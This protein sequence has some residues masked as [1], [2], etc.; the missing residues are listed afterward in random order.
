MSSSR[1][2]RLAIVAVAV[3]ALVAGRLFV[4]R[5]T[6]PTRDC[7]PIAAHPEWS[8]ARRWDEALLDAIRRA[9]PNPPVHARNLFHASVA[10][11]DAW[12]TY[13]PKASG[14]L[15]TEKHTAP[16]VAA[17]R[18]EAI[19][20]AAYRVLS[21]RY[22]KAVGGSDSLSEFDDV[23]DSLCYP[24][25]TTTTD[26]DSPAAIGNRI[27]ATVL[28]AAKS[29]GSNEANGYASDYK[30]VNP[31]LVVDK[32]GA[33]P[34]DPN[35]WQP[36]QLEHMISQN[37]IPVTNGVQQ[38]IGPHWGHVTS[39]ALP[40]GGDAGTP[41]DPGPPPQLGG[42]IASDQAY[43]DQAV[44][45]IRDSSLLDPS[46]GTMIDVSPAARG[47]NSLGS[48]DG[49]GRPTNPETGKPYEPERVNQGDFYRVMAEFW[50]DGPKSE[51][52]PGHWNVLANAASDELAPNLRIGGTGPAVDRLQWDVK[53][54]LALNGAV[55]DAA[56][57]AWGLKGRYDSV[58]PITMIRYMGGLGQSSDPKGPSYNR[59]GLPLVPGLIEVVTKESSA[60]RQRHAALARSIGKI[61]IKAWGGI[62]ADPKTQTSGARWML[63]GD[64]VPYQ[65]PTFVTPSFPAFVSGHSTFSRAAA[66]VLTGFTGSE[67]FPG[68]V[69][70]YTIK[71]GSLKFEHGPT[72][73]IRLEWATYYDAADQAG[74]SRLLGG[75]HIQAD[76][77]TG[78]I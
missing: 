6:T 77:F 53:L 25:A 40:P 73:D 52:P 51:T 37:G 72:T 1:R 3:V 63:A 2:T 41:I 71:A 10:M 59:E 13:D 62:P 9:L 26:G 50:A 33:N 42:D 20:Y 47:G 48:N 22:I 60:P 39:F 21:A 54:Y 46:A 5:N 19:S 29:D 67:Y 64:W 44:E 65:L 4:W 49:H 61:A 70:G 27:A 76:D 56:I 55:H 12:A 24:L 30:P 23:M 32:T 15:F 75:I 45:I 18:D 36:L 68:G 28:A 74:Q 31:P 66:E 7:P 11:W 38:A 34:T 58:R 17:A 14:D 35:R 8:V 69:S 57:A 78:R 43:K 16:D